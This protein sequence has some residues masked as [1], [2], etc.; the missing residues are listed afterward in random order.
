MIGGRGVSKTLST[1][2]ILEMVAYKVK[3]MCGV[4]AEPSYRAQ[5][6]HQL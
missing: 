1:V 4:L 6:Q 2:A 3:M 5:I